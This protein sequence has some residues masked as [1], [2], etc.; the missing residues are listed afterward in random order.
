M[1]E[2]DAA[3]KERDLGLDEKIQALTKRIDNNAALLDDH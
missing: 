2:N 3:S 1:R